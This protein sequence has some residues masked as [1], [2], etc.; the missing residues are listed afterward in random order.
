MEN[1]YINDAMSENIIQCTKALALENGAGKLNVRTVLNSLGITNRVFYNR[2]SNIE[3]VLDIVYCRMVISM[4]ESLCFDIDPQRD[5]FEQVKDIVVSTLVSSYQL[6]MKF[7]SYV[8]ESDSE[9]DENFRWW[10]E[11]IGELIKKGKKLGFLL[12][13]DEKRTAYSVWCFIRG[14]NADALSRG[15][16][17]EQATEDFK[18][19]FGIF[20]NGMRKED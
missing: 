14:Y 6:K 3:Q 19:S 10:M 11:R 5:F 17:M 15:I 7:N 13:V 20:L 12:D 18:Y 4:R 16:P 2:F 8:F 1:K 9:T